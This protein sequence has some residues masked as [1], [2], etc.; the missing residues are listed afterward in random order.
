MDVNSDLTAFILYET[1]CHY[2]EDI[3][4]THDTD[5]IE[6]TAFLKIKNTN[7]HQ[8]Y[9]LKSSSTS[10]PTAMQLSVDM[11]DIRVVDSRHCVISRNITSTGI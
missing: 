9:T 7:Y 10:S 1:S 8:I 5:L 2:T 4:S 11:V 3:H 6:D